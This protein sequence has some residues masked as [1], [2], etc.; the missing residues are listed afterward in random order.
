MGRISSCTVS[1][2]GADKFMNVSVSGADKF[3]NVFS[4]DIMQL[5]YLRSAMSMLNAKQ[6]YGLKIFC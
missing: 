1:V 2:S 6:F 4:S 5:S 3:M